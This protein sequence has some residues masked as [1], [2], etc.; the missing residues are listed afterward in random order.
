VATGVVESSMAR[1]RLMKVPQFIGSAA[2][3][4]FIAILLK[5]IL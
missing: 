1:L 2:A 4:A 5:G 3:F